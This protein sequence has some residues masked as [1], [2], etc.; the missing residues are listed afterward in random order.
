MPL[1]IT[2]KGA[3]TFLWFSFVWT[4]ENT[5]EKKQWIYNDLLQSIFL[6]VLIS[7]CV[8]LW[9]NEFRVELCVFFRSLISA[10]SSSYFFYIIEQLTQPNWNGTQ[11]HTQKNKRP[12][13]MNIGPFWTFEHNPMFLSTCAFHFWLGLI[14][15]IDFVNY[16]SVFVQ[17]FSGGET[18]VKET[19]IW[20]FYS[21]WWD[22]W[23]LFKWVQIHTHTQTRRY[24]IFSN[25]YPLI[26]YLFHSNEH[27]FA[28][29][30][31]FYSR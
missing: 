23:W 7:S 27:D 18:L 29:V 26:K 4:T 15:K 11:L 20:L 17:G 30:R 8:G 1:R 5:S 12:P 24:T 25:W 28:V 10:S 6:F 9:S 13:Q 14:I 31:L 19:W 16:C 22:V 3:Y 21:I 2:I